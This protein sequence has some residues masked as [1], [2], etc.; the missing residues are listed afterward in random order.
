MNLLTVDNLKVSFNLRIGKVQAVNDV[1]LTLDKGEIVGLVGESGSGKSVLCLSMLRLI[2]TPPGEIEKGRVVFNGTDLITCS[3]KE[4]RTIRGNLISMIFQD[5]MTSLNPY[6]TI[7]AQLTEP[8]IVHKEMNK[9]E[10]LK[11]AVAA[12]HE[13]GIAEPDRRIHSYP[14]EFS[15][16]M[17]QRVMIAMA[18]I[19]HWR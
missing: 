8:L 18:L 5:P 14:H 10:A 15:G 11:T 7:A 2:P 17:R 16:G 19:T 13:V 6:L 4:I 3:E 12:M 9:K 1:S